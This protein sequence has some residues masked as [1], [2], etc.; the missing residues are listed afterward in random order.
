MISGVDFLTVPTRKFEEATKFY[1]NVLGLPVGKEYRDGIGRE[2]ETG[3]LTLQLLNIEKLGLDLQPSTNP[4]A[5]HVEDFEGARSDLSERGVSFEGDTLD[6]G[7]C[8]HAFFKDPDGNMLA[9]HHRYAPPDAR[10]GD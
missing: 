3:N 10:P 6:S 7:V 9:I 8:W 5:L 4:I 1:E 2:Y